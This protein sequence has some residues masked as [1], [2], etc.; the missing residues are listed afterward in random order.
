MRAKAAATANG[1][2][3]GP[4][5]PTTRRPV[6]VSKVVIRCTVKALKLL[7]VRLASLVEIEPDD[8]DWYVN[9]LW[10]DRR[11]CLLLTHA[12]TTFSVFVPDVRKADLDPFGRFLADVVVVAL[13]A[14]GL[15]RDVLGSL[16]TGGVT[17]ARTASRRVLGVMNDIAMHIEYALYACGGVMDVDVVTLNR[18]L[19]RTLHS[20][21]GGYAKPIDLVRRRDGLGS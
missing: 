11:K 12:G 9:L 5:D 2:T 21:G 15:P 8:D 10:F 4:E 6:S 7:G 13:D 1:T 16:D 19:Q 17:V 20:Y 14:E 18:E 3:R